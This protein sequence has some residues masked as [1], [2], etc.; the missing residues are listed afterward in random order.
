VVSDEGMADALFDYYNGI[1]GNNF[2]RTRMLNL[3]AI[4]VP[5]L[6]LHTLEFLFS[7]EEVHAVVMELPADKAPGLDGFT[8]RFY[9]AAWNI[10][11]GDIMNAINAFWAHDT[12]SFHHLNDAYMIL[13][14]KKEG[15]EEIREYRPISLIHS[16]GKLVTKCMA[17][18]LARFL[19][20]LVTRNQTAFIKGRSIHE[21]FREVQLACKALH[22]SRSP[23]V[24]LKIDIAKA[25]DT[26]AWEFLLDVLQHMGF[27]TRW[28]NWI[29][30]IL[31]SSSSK[32]L[33]NGHP[34]R[35]IC[36]ARVLRQGDPLSP[37]LFVLVMDVLNHFL[38]WVDQRQ[39]LTPVRGVA[40]F[41]VS[42]Y[43]DDLVILVAPV[44]RDL[45]AIKAAL[46]IFGLAS[47]LF[48]NFDKSVAT[49]I[50]C[51]MEDLQRLNEVLAC[52]VEHFPC[53]YLGIPL[54]VF[55]LKRSEEQFLIDKVAARI[56]GWK[57]NLL[58]MAGRT[59]LVKAT[60]SAIP[61]HVSI[62]LC[63]SPW[64]IGEIVRLRRAF[65]WTGSEVAAGGRCRVAWTVCC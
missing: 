35:R 5:S 43:A 3:Q 23:C 9:K 51:T 11:K 49:P 39:L 59:A 54:S 64:A 6:D 63:L 4:G 12:R 19:D 38:L 53:R 62:A 57:G 36:H 58:S 1:L 22:A 47:G 56:P 61:V 46:Q 52:R 65:I 25:F 31:S 29:A 32:V 10:I 2:V 41:R 24:M 42:L 26:V 7:E 50:H 60:L 45:E 27:G 37:M 55:K 33:L 40:D 28:R 13:L 14:K 17:N 21:N 8:G 15:A 16:F 34:G 18:R 44:T 20:Q 30:A 48:S